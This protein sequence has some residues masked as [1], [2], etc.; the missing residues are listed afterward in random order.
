[1]VT[2]YLDNTLQELLTLDYHVFRVRF[3]VHLQSNGQCLPAAHT[4]I[5]MHCTCILHMSLVFVLPHLAV[6][7]ISYFYCCLIN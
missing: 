7:T 3:N 6:C 5:F 2:S 4:M 1:M